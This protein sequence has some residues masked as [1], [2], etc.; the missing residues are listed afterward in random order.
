MDKCAVLKP[1]Q[2]KISLRILVDRAIIE[3]F[4]NEG[5]VYMPIGA[6]DQDENKGLEFLAE[7]GE[8]VLTSLNISSLS[9]IWT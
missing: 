4:G 8:A 3:I 1:Q 5:L 2:K 6:I 7:G 9:S